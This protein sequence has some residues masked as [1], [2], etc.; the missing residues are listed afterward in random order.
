MDRKVLL[1]SGG[2][3]SWLVDKL[4]KPDVKLFFDIGTAN[5]KAE[6]ERVKKRDDVEIIKLP[7]GQFEQKENNYFLPL[8]NLHFVVMAAHYGNVICLGATGSSTH[9][10]KSDIFAF[11]T[12][13]VIN[14]LNS[15]IAGAPEVKIV[16]PYRGKSKTNILRKYLQQGGDIE[17]CYNSTFSCYNPVDGGPCMECTSCQ[18]KFTAFYNNGYKF[19][20][21]QI[22]KFVKGALNNKCVKDEP[23]RL[24]L[25]LSKEIV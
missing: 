6:L 10:D 12:A 21:E 23:Y 15:E 1:Y 19:S 2:M 22:A 17:E 18:G 25:K 4:W 24:A 9:R 3:D 20:E 14:Y 5:N 7:L 11:D 13:N 16:M 8:R